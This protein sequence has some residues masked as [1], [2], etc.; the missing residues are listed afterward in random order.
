MVNSKNAFVHLSL[1]EGASTQVRILE[2]NID[3]EQLCA[4]I[5]AVHGKS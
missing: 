4:P 2:T 5:T 1:Y 3:F